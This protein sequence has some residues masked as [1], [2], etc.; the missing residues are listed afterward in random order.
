MNGKILS[1]SSYDINETRIASVPVTGRWRKQ[2]TQS[3]KISDP[4][5]PGDGTVPH[6]SGI[7]PM[8][9]CQSLLR[10]NVEHEPAYKYETGADNLRACHFALRAIVK[11]AQ[12]VQETSLRYE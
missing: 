12:G 3:Y 8:S 6:R 10:V 7:A 4:N 9:Y 1:T 5:E 2:V 11:I